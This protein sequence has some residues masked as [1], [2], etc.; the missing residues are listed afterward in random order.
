TQT[1]V[2]V[3]HTECL[4]ALREEFARQHC[5]ILP[6]LLEPCLLESVRRQLTVATFRLTSHFDV[7]GEREFAKDLTVNGMAL[8]VHLFHMLLNSLPLFQAIQQITRCAAIG[9]FAGRIYRTLPDSDH[10]LSWHDDNTTGNHLI[11]LSINLSPETYSG[12]VF[13]LRQ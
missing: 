1:G 5:V 9:S 11:G 12:G 8:V 3:A 2:V 6:R 4:A 10:H 13:Q 7:A